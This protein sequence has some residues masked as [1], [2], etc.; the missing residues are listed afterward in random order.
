MKSEILFYLLYTFLFFQCLFSGPGIMFIVNRFFKKY[1]VVKMYTAGFFIPFLLFYAKDFELRTS[2]FNKTDIVKLKIKRIFFWINP[3]YLFIGKIRFH[4]FELIEPDMKYVNRIPS[5]QKMKY[6]PPINKVTIRSA[7]IKKGF[8]EIEDRTVF[9]L[10]KSKIE[11]IEVDNSNVDFGIPLRFIFDSEYA[12]C[13]IDS[14]D[15]LSSCENGEGTMQV[16][17]VTWAKLANLDLISVGILKNKID[18]HVSFKHK[19][20]ISD[21]TGT[22]GQIDRNPYK[23]NEKIE[24]QKLEYKFQLDW[25][26][27][28]MPFDLA[29]KKMISKLLIGVNYGGAINITVNMIAEGMGKLLNKLNTKPKENNKEVEIESKLEE[30]IKTDEEEDVIDKSS[31]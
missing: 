3:I 18:L 27:Y 2:G 22:L 26:D 4:Y 24:K 11:N 30:E 19:K 29:L 15:I 20:N 8:I 16:Q 6:M 21:F 1:L 12:Y 17:G 31:E 10:Y 28:Q 7:W 5:I 9:P 14:G 13:K 23:E 25:N